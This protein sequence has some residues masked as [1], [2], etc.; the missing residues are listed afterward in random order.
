MDRNVALLAEMQHELVS[1]AQAR[2][3]G[4]TRHAIELRDLVRPAELPVPV[5]QLDAGDADRWVGR[6]DVAW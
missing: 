2:Q 6:A 5:R 3:L 1:I 4:A